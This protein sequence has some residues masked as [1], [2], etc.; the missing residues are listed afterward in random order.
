M[1]ESSFLAFLSQPW[2]WWV[3]GPLIGLVVTALLVVGGKAFGVSSSLRHACAATLPG[4]SSYL[5]YDWLK[6]GLWNLLFVVG[7]ALGGLVA[8]QLIPN[9]GPVPISEATRHDLAE[10]GISTGEPGGLVPEEVY[11]LGALASTGGI[12]VMVVGGFLVG[13]GARY[14]GGCTSGHGVMGLATFQLPS[15]VAVLGFF[16]GGLVATHFLL[17]MVLQGMSG[18]GGA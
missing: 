2:P 16:L 5:K 18:G 7:I 11:S 14:G 8:G 10:L 3:A 6:K 9:P 17:P 12:L 15:L 4:K 13:F 1:T